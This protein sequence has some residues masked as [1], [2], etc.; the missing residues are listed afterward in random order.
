[1]MSFAHHLAVFA[2]AVPPA[3]GLHV[4]CRLK[5]GFSEELTVKAAQSAGIELPTLRRLYAGSHADEG[6]LM[7]FAALTAHEIDD[8]M[9]R[10]SL[11]VSDAVA[12]H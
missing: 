6:W 2:D 7:G 8:G 10:L 9:R 12:N 11:A 5:P 3:G 4:A 1:M